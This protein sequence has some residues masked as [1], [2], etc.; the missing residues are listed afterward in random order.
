MKWVDTPKADELIKESLK[1]IRFI[2]NCFDRLNDGT[3]RIK[4]DICKNPVRLKELE[5]AE[6][7]LENIYKKCAWH[8]KRFNKQL[9]GEKI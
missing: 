7:R 6:H 4:I 8:E 9:C 2:N 3:K 1:E 5:M